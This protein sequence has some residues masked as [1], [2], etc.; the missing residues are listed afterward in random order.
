MLNSLTDNVFYYIAG[1]VIKKILPLLICENCIKA[2]TDASYVQ[3]HTYCNIE[4]ESFKILTRIKNRGG[5]ELASDSVFRVIKT[6]ETYFKSVVSNK[7]TVV[8]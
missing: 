7:A 8:T 6:T 1:Y 2:V 5:L 4:N 3:E